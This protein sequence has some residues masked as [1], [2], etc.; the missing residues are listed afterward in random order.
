MRRGGR[1]AYRRIGPPLAY[2]GVATGSIGIIR[3]T[4]RLIVGVAPGD[5][6]HP[7]AARAGDTTTVATTFPLSKGMFAR[8]RCFVVWPPARGKDLPVGRGASLWPGAPYGL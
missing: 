2:L 4:L 1:D 6:R 8:G 3:E 5:V 7:M